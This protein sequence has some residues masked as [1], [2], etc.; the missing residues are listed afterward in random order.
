MT[1]HCERNRASDERIISSSSTIR[2]VFANLESY[3]S[4]ARGNIR[5]VTYEGAYGRTGAPLRA[6]VPFA[7]ELSGRE[8]DRPAARQ[9]LAEVDATAHDDFAEVRAVETRDARGRRHVSVRHAKERAHVST[10]E[11]VR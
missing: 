10:L 8:V 5:N 9:E 7:A 3:R 1:R 6:P 4:T 11:L 2:T